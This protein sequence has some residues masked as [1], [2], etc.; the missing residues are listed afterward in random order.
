MPVQAAKRAVKNAAKRVATKAAD[1]RDHW[2]QQEALRR[3][4]MAELMQQRLV[5]ALGLV[6]A[7]VGKA[8]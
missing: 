3:R 4:E 1:V 7:R 8:K 6:P 2:T 5:D